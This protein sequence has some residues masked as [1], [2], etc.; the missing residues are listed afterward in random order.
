[1]TQPGLH[2]GFWSN[3]PAEGEKIAS[4]VEPPPPLSEARRDRKMFQEAAF[5]I[6]LV[7]PWKR[8]KA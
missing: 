3:W 1:M 5:E 8:G 6:W 2:A 7:L 4:G